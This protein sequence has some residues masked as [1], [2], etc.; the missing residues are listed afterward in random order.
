MIKIT[1]NENNSVNYD[2]SCGV[3]G[4]CMIKPMG[5]AGIIIVNIRCPVCL[6]IERI[7]LVPYKKEKA[8]D[9]SWACVISNE[10]TGYY[11]TEEK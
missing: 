8:E 10:V 2:C 5:D 9:Y 7:K 11:L 1:G 4:K 3:K 6:A